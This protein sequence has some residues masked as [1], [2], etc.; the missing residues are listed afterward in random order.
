MTLQVQHCAGEVGVAGELTLEVVQRP[1]V[2]EITT[3]SLSGVHPLVE[4]R[5]VAE[6]I[7]AAGVE[8]PSK[9]HHLES[10]TY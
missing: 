7:G 3:S 9:T 1:A 8:T 6:R 10:E 2:E 5:G 4:D